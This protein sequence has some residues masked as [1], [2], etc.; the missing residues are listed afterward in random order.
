KPRARAQFSHTNLF[1]ELIRLDAEATFGAAVIDALTSEQLEWV[2]SVG[3]TLRWPRFAGPRW[4]L[5]LAA[6][7]TRDIQSGLWLYEQPEADL[8]LAWR[9]TDRITLRGGPHWEQYE[10]L[11]L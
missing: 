4:D 7:Y 6:N 2:W 9:P 1:G 3:G 10:F 11:T 5:E 8:R